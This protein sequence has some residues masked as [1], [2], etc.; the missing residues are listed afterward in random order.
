M[1]DHL[2][3][4]TSLGGG[5]F[6]EVS[7]LSFNH[8]Q[9][10]LLSVFQFHLMKEELDTLSAFLLKNQCWELIG[11]PVYHRHEDI[12]TQDDSRFAPNQSK[13]A[14]LCNNIFHWL[15]AS[16]DSTLWHKNVF[17]IIDPLVESS[18]CH[19]QTRLAYWTHRNKL[20]WNVN[21]IQKSLSLRT[22]SHVSSASRDYSCSDLCM[23]CMTSW[24][25]N[26][27]RITGPLCGDSPVTGEF[28]S[29]RLATRSKLWW[30]FWVCAW[31]NG[32]ANNWDAI[33]LIMTSL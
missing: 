16:L 21:H 24:N 13:T 25:G 26:I 33:M 7:N 17:R 4:K 10:S 12:M 18:T 28:P 32:W 27:F 9:N 3:W 31:T 15:G 8:R 6:G 19:K 11:S 14:L 20:Q 23:F 29:Q 2:S 30:V 5:L 1:R 22:C